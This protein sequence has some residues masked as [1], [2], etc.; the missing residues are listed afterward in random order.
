MRSKLRL[1]LIFGLC[2][3][4]LNGCFSFSSH[5]TADTVPEGDVEFGTAQGYNVI[6]Y[7]QEDWSTCDEDYDNCQTEKKE[8]YWPNFGE[9]IIRIGLD[10]DMDMGVKL[11]GLVTNIEMDLKYRFFTTGGE[12]DRFSLAVQ[13]L[14]SVMYL[15]PFK[16]YK[17]ALGLIAS[18]RV[19]KMV[20]F[21]GNIKY[22]RFKLDYDDEPVENED[23]D[24]QYFMNGNA[25][26]AT[27]GLSIEGKKFW[28]RPEVTFLFDKNWDSNVYFPSIGFGV[29]L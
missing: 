18:K 10:K 25:Y 19:S 3:F 20:G 7:E 22:N 8:F 29:K 23:G 11:S 24:D 5:Q 12:T 17:V 15:G 1:F 6:Q 21:Y 2:L 14:G 28:L 26:S 9:M 16:F 4:L 27:I 13:P